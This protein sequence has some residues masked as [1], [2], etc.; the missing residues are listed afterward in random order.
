MVADHQGRRHL[1][2]LN[3]SGGAARSRSARPAKAGTQ[4]SVVNQKFATF[5]AVGGSVVSAEAFDG[6]EDVVC[7]L[8]P[9]KGL[10]V[11]IVAGDEGGDVGLE[12]DNAS[13]DSTSDLL[14]R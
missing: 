9:S 10:G 13:I 8:C 3:G 1:R 4:P 11:G 2:E 6:S 5:S 12:S 7:R 14:V